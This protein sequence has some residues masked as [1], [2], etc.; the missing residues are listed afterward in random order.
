[1]YNK[2]CFDAKYIATYTITM[3]SQNEV[4]NALKILNTYE[5]NHWN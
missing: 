3:Y 5:T 4:D 2:R 1:M